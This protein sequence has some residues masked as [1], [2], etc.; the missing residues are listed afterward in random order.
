MEARTFC[1]GDPNVYGEVTLDELLAE[2]IVRLVM[3]RDGV[4]A[5]SIRDLASELRERLR[6]CQLGACAGVGAASA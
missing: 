6:L 2:P 3:A 1:K 4:D 5:R